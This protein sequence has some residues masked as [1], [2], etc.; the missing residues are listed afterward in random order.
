[1]TRAPPPPA[2]DC[3]ATALGALWLRVGLQVLVTV[4]ALQLQ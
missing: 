1:M 2:L 4:E 3:S